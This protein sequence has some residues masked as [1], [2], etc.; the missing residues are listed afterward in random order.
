MAT[1]IIRGLPEFRAALKAIKAEWPAEMTATH[2][3]LAAKA[4]GWSREEAARMGGV[5]AKAKSAIGGIGT[6]S[7]ASVAVLPSRYDRMGNIAFWGAKR[8]TGWYADHRYADSPPQHPPWVGNS[9]DVG[10]AGEGPY[11]INPALAAHMDGILDE[12]RTMIDV[13]TRRPFPDGTSIAS[14]TS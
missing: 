4:A 1:E 8:H 5:Q 7:G 2:K 11:A 6:L 13:L 10:V 9:W 14:R 3:L 12:Y